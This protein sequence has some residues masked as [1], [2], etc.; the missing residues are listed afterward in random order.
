MADHMT[1]DVVR[2]ADYGPAEQAEILGDGP[3]PYGV[4]DTGLTFLPKEIHFGV[5]G[6]G[7][8]LLAH[9]GL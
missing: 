1:P 7:G 2:L 8:R 4:A 5:R 9:S 3:D 6:E